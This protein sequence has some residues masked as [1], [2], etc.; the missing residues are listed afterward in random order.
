MATFVTCFYDLAA[1]EK[2]DRRSGESYLE[3]GKLM[4]QQNINFVIFT[5]PRFVDTI[6]EYRRGF[7]DK[8]KI[9]ALDYEQLDTYKYIDQMKQINHHVVNNGKEVYTHLYHIII[10]QKLY[11]IERAIKLNL[12]KSDYFGWID[13]GN[14]YVNTA[15]PKDNPF[16]ITESRIKI[17]RMCYRRYEVRPLHKFYNFNLRMMAGGYFTGDIEHMLWF[18]TTFEKYLLEALD[19]GYIVSEEMLFTVITHDH[20][21]RFKF[22]YGFFADI[23][24]H[25]VIE[26]NLQYVNME[27][28]CNR[29]KNHLAESEHAVN[30]IFPKLDLWKY[31][32]DEL[33]TF[34]Y[35][36]YL[37]GFYHNRDYAI[38][39]VNKYISEVKSNRNF[40]NIFLANKKHILDNFKFIADSVPEVKILE[41]IQKDEIDI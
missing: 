2:S 15:F 5:E 23:L 32:S 21:E 14:K 7:E 22:Y 41:S 28:Q 4:M 3:Y 20:P 31:H 36:T 40:L 18:K 19:Y 38:K 8:T 9:I 25:Y 12:F 1:K 26:K 13:F 34:L 30:T 11:F 27:L 35:E 16:H 33:H 24:N 29:S 10:W 17:L 39:A 37:Y 6:T